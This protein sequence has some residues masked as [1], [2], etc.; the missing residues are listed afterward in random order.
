MNDSKH[1]SRKPTRWLAL[2]DGSPD[3]QLALDHCF[4]YSKDGDWIIILRAL[5][6]Q[7]T[8]TEIKQH[9]AKLNALRDEMVDKYRPK[10]LTVEANLLV[11][12]KVK[13]KLCNKATLLG[14]DVVVMGSRGMGE[15]KGVVL[16]SV[17]K[18]VLEK[19]TCSVLVVQSSKHHCKEEAAELKA[20]HKEES[21]EL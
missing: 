2:Y 12:S 7:A 16:G 4:K 1:T 19:A 5:E 14:V 3:A 11:S 9:Q 20:G 21:K 18:H 6:W 10:P 15:F 17:S 8:L 13:R